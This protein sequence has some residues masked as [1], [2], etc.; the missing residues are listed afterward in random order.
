MAIQ[1]PLTDP[2]TGAVYPVAY[3]RVTGYALRPLE[4]TATIYVDAYVDATNAGA[5]KV[6]V[7]SL[8]L[9]MGTAAYATVFA[10]T[11]QVSTL[12]ARVYTWLKARAEFLAGIDV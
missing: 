9:A 11:A 5:A 12:P 6:P 2:D 7:R 4:Q 3:W 10:P 1:L 8:S